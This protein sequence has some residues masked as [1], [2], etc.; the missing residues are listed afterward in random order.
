MKRWTDCLK[1]GRLPHCGSGEIR[2]F[3]ALKWHPV[4]IWLTAGYRWRIA[5]QVESLLKLA[6]L[7]DSSGS[8]GKG[9]RQ[10]ANGIRTFSDKRREWIIRA[11]FEQKTLSLKPSQR[12]GGAESQRIT[13]S[14]R[15]ALT[16]H[17]LHQGTNCRPLFRRPLSP[18]KS[19]RSAPAS[20]VLT[21]GGTRHSHEDGGLTPPVFCCSRSCNASSRV[22]LEM[23]SRKS[24]FTRTGIVFN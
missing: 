12:T 4:L 18:V 5:E 21:G 13:V 24:S 3:S 1:P 17:W 22:T 16:N 6:C 20:A 11:L 23:L 15:A 14:I 7:Q 8:S 10:F 19:A 9:I 2:C